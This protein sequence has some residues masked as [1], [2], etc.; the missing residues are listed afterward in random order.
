MQERGKVI[1]EFE[2]NG[3]GCRTG[4][5]RRRAKMGEV[6]VTIPATEGGRRKGRTKKSREGKSEK[7][8]REEVGGIG[9]GP[10]TRWRKSRLPKPKGG[11]RR[12]S[13]PRK[14]TAI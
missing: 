8:T 12:G 11:G 6:F 4:G 13:L 10:S 2:G 9:R 7:R 14:K 1:T 5:E 3:G